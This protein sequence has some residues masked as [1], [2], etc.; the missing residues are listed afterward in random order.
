MT[1]VIYVNYFSEVLLMDSIESV[2][3]QTTNAAFQILVANNGGS[4]EDL[5]TRFPEVEI[6]DCNE[7][8]G[9]GKANNIAAQ[10]AKSEYLLF[11]NPDTVL[12]SDVVSEMEFFFTSFSKELQIGALGGSIYDLEGNNNFSSNYFPSIRKDITYLANGLFSLLGRRSLRYSYSNVVY[13]RVD[14]IIGCNL[15][16][17]RRVFHDIK[18]FD[19]NFFMYFE[20]VDFCFR[21]LKDKKLTCFILSG[22]KLVHLEGGSSK[23]DSKYVSFK[24]YRFYIDSLHYYIQ[25]HSDGLFLYLIRRIYFG[26][27]VSLNVLF[28]GLS[29]RRVFNFSYKEKRML[30]AQI[31]RK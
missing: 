19:E 3:K 18:G 9:Y 31:L 23:G 10:N 21:L 16:V 5:I 30:L 17:E 8:L 22:A 6:V 4:L 2:Y 24:T 1:T 28:Q 13:E 7:N 29:F 26:L 11:L 14:A 25:K 12:K 15:F 27:I 20:D